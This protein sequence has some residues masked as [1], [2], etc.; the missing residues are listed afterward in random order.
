[1]TSRILLGLLASIVLL[2]SGCKDAEQTGGTAGVALY[3][4]DSSSSAVFVW[5]DLSTVYDG[6]ATTVA[7]SKQ[8]TSSVFGSKIDSLTWGGMCF[9]RQR[10]Y[11]YLVSVTGN[12][13]RVRNIRSQS[14]DVPSTDIVSFALSSTGRL[15]VSS[16]G[17][18]ALDGDSDTLYIT[19]NGS[20]GTQIWVVA[21]ASTQTQ[22]ATV[23]LQA[24]KMAGD[25]G[26]TGVAA[27]GGAVYGFMLNGDTVGTVEVY[28]GARLRKGTSAAFSDTNTL[29]GSSTL[30]GQYGSLAFDKA[31][32]NLY[33]ARH[34]IDAGASTAPIQVFASGMFS[35]GG[36]NQ[37]AAHSLGSTTD[38][39][40]LRVIAHP[41]NKDW[42][43]GLRG[44]G[45]TAYGT[46]C[47]WKSPLGGTAAKV[48]TASPATALFK[49]VALD[50][51]A[52]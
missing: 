40:D 50:G 32:S 4:Y 38:Q 19:E 49:G 6:T 45:T 29:I 2:F 25:T 9:D 20:A 48:I 8:I 30:L 26:G 1:M 17:Q 15:S 44:N 39:A 33:V 52:S 51:N 31:N 21:N 47:I 11:L 16:F 46:I 43:A 42:L 13:V 5:T 36:H 41:G 28:S 22:S 18:A 10:G 23:E 12:I 27:D 34:N 7:P 14:G 37:A 3:A 35:S 24:L